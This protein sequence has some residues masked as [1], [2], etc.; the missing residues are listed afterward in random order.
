ML[1]AIRLAG[2]WLRPTVEADWACV[3]PLALLSL[4]AL[5]LVRRREYELNW[6]AGLLVAVSVLLALLDWL[7]GR[8]R[9]DRFRFPEI[10]RVDRV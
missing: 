1:L 2:A 10:L 3:V 5:E 8:G 4:I 6:G 7:E 9:L